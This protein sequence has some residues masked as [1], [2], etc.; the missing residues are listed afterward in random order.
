M[1]KQFKRDNLKTITLWHR[2]IHV[3]HTSYILHL[4]EVLT[5]SEV[6]NVKTNLSCFDVSIDERC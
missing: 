3:I 2:S 4:I 1:P 6:R 5:E